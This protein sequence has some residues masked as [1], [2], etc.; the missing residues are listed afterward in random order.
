MP[1]DSEDCL[2]HHVYHLLGDL[3]LERPEKYLNEEELAKLRTLEPLIYQLNEFTTFPE[4]ETAAWRHLGA[5]RSRELLLHPSGDIDSPVACHIHNPTY[6]VKNLY[7]QE[8]DNQS[9]PTIQQLNQAGFSSRNCLFFDHICRRNRTDDVLLFYNHDILQV[10]EEFMLSIRKTMAAKVEICWGKH[11]RERMKRLLTLTPLKLWGQFRDIELFLE[12]QNQTALRFIIFVAHPQFLFY[13]GSF[14]ESGL[15]FRETQARK[16]D[17]YLTVASKLGGITVTRNFYE[18]VHRPALYGQFDMVSR[19]LV[20][21]LEANA[22]AQLKA[23]FPVFSNEAKGILRRRQVSHARKAYTGKYTVLILKQTLRRCHQFAH[24]SE[25]LIEAVGQV[26]GQDFMGTAS[27]RG[28]AQG[29]SMFILMSEWDGIMEWEQLPNPLLSND[30]TLIEVVLQVAV[31]YISRVKKQRHSSVRDLIIAGVQPYNVMRRKC[32]KC[33][34]RVLDDAFACFA[35]ADPQ[36]MSFGFAN[37]VPVDPNQGYR[38]A[39]CQSLQCLRTAEWEECLL[40]CSPEERRKSSKRSKRFPRWTS[41]CPSRYVIPI[42]GC[43]NCT[44]KYRSFVPTDNE[45][46]TITQ[47][48]VSKKWKDLKA[49]G[50]EAT[51]Y[52]R[53]PDILWSRKSHLTKLQELE[54]G[55]SPA[56]TLLGE[57]VFHKKRVP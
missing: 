9:S 46:P 28:I 25:T 11:V 30:L 35:K 33:G 2:F 17:L 43:K 55:L 22:D 44:K 31:W 10:H 15:R 57:Y 48:A 24:A 16:Q 36:N 13:H 19:R 53:R 39:T 8:T 29:D 50:I 49:A 40:R 20:L 37:L 5:N 56:E 1:D 3:C 54:L 7:C 18:R 45:I 12:M 52:P 41:E 27:L 4:R 51:D 23:A 6:Y 47:A 38:M 42:R 34:E 26:A 21:Q 14:T 32:A